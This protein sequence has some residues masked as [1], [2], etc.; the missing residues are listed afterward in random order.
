MEVIK[1][2]TD[3]FSSPEERMTYKC[4]GHRLS[5]AEMEEVV[6]PIIPWLNVPLLEFTMS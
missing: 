2:K 5:T 4:S 1:M 6:A 3:I